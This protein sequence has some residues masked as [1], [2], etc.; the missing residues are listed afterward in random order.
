MTVQPVQPVQPI[1]PT[2]QPLQPLH[3]VRPGH[4]RQYAPTTD[5]GKRTDHRVA[6]RVCIYMAAAHFFGGFLF[7][8]FYLGAHTGH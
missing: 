3:P 6:I 1:Q 8:L 5:A 7:L 2:T 4:P